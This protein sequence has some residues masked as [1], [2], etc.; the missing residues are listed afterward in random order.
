M[1]PQVRREK[2]LVVDDS[3]VNIRILADGLKSN[4]ELIVATSGEAA[5]RR[6]FSDSPPDLVLLDVMMP[7]MDGYEVCRRLKADERTKNIPVIFITARNTEEDETKGLELGAIDFIAK[8]F[9]L[10]IVNAR[11]RTHL[12]LKRK[13]DIL[14]SLAFLDG[15]TGIPNRR[16]FDTVLENEWKRAAR[17]AQ[18]LA[19]IMIDIDHFKPFNDTYGHGAG[20]KCLRLVADVLRG[21]QKRAS[22]FVAR[23]GGEEFASVLPGAGSREATD[24]GEIMRK[25]VEAM[26]IEHSGSSSCRVTISL[27]ISSVI[28]S[29]L[30]SPSLLKEAADRALYQAKAEGRNRS[31]SVDLS[32]EPVQIESD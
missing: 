27:G 19:L 5:L 11:V 8:P 29:P 30:S 1:S 14:E 28:P 32:E 31:R 7:V 24:L 2:I 21:C 23:Y 10:A 9:S 22:D 13:S 20:D 15:L 16:R 3:P 25:K 6:A 12:E 17:C 4:Y 26:N 18:P